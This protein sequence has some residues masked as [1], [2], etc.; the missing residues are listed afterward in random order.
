MS[1]SEL[2]KKYKSDFD[3]EIEK[4]IDENSVEKIRVKFLGRKSGFVTDLFKKL[5]VSSKKE[6]PLLGKHVNE[7]KNYVSDSLSAR[8]N[9]IKNKV[10]K[11]S[12][13]DLSLPGRPQY[14][15]RLHPLTI[16]Q[17]EMISIFEGMGF[18]VATGPDIENE[19]YNFEALNF[20][21]DHPA[22]DLQDTFYLDD[23]RLL[24]THTSP[25]QI[26]VM[27]S[28]K[29]PVRIIAPGRVFRKDTPDATHSPVF[30]Q[31]EGLYVDENVTLAELKGTLLAFARALFGP[32]MNIRFR[33]GFFPFT[34]PSVEYD[35]TCVMCEGQGCSI[36]KGT[37][38]IEISGAGM[39]DPAVFDAVGYD[40]KKFTGYAW[41]MGVER[42][43]MLKYRIN[44]IRLF[45]ENDLRFLEQFS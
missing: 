45:Y 3:S 34:E 12:I 20:P 36:C 14:I 32:K 4:T 17:N 33:S 25:V 26:R 21:K 41:G 40:S 16:I 6:R 1:L 37:G 2:I 27:E 18:E 29:P 31:V 5:S 15:G 7:F 38:W 19:Y 11:K 22:K 23:G 28:T 24:R 13:I 39:V 35:F 8:E 43:A 30:Y 9:E 44:D 42:I 10:E